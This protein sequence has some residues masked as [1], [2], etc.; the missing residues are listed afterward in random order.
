MAAL[1]GLKAYHDDLLKLNP[2]PKYSELEPQERLGGGLVN[3]FTS[4]LDL[5]SHLHFVDSTF[6]FEVH[7]YP[8]HTF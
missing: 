6:L 8:I 7:D 2:S 3:L 1:I 4:I 5:P